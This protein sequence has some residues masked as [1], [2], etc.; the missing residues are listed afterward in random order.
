MKNFI[1]IILIG[2]CFVFLF[3]TR[4]FSQGN[5]HNFDE[6]NLT[7]WYPSTW[8]ISEHGLH[9]LMPKDEDLSFQFEVL[10]APDFENALKIS[11]IELKAIFAKEPDLIINDIDINGMSAKE[12]NKVVGAKEA[13]YYTIQTPE[14]KY[15]RFFCITTSDILSKHRAEIKKIMEN[16]KSGS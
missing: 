9:F 11:V 8:N 12:I 7:I 14:N 2:L 15:V 1:I 3:T 5:T 16:L 4:T 13:L 10:N 6:A